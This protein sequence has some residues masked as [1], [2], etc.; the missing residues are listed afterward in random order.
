M[1]TLMTKC[2]E[3]WAETLAEYAIPL[4]EVFKKCLYPDLSCSELQQSHVMFESILAFS[5]EK[6][7]CLAWRREFLGIQHFFFFFTVEEGRVVA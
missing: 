3:L 5:G 2:L 7:K 6:W 4:R 1:N